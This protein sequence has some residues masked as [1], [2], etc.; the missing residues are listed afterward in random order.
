[1]LH[2]GG[3]FSTI[4]LSPDGHTALTGADDRTARL[5]DLTTRHSIDPV[6]PHE[7]KVTAVAISHDGQMFAT[8]DEQGFVRLWDRADRRRPRHELRCTGWI[9]AIALSPDDRTAL[10]AVGYT[11]GLSG[12]GHKALLWDTASG[13]VL[14]D[15]LPHEGT[16]SAAGWSPDGQTL[17]TADTGGAQLWD[18]ATQRPVGGRTGGSSAFPAAIFPDGRNI[19]LLAN[20]I[21][22]LWDLRAGRVTGPPP[23]NPEGGIR[24]VALSPDG[25]SILISALD[26]VVRLWDVSTGKVLGRPVISGGSDAGRVQCQRSDDG[27][28][29][30]GRKNRCLERA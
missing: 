25:Q 9:A 16:A 8:G 14:G 27:R 21:P 23:F 18:A 28:C 4:A 20:G 7:R 12:S 15:P 5:W 10:I 13:K 22:H 26:G 11:M 6:M 19:L 30:L 24:R 1:M 17:F 29:R 2:S 3:Q